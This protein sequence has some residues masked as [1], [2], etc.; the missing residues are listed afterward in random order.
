V[1]DGN[2]QQLRDPVAWR[3]LEFERWIGVEQQHPHLSPVA[4][5][6]QAGRVEEGDA[7]LERHA[8]A[9]QHQSARAV[10]NLHGETGADADPGPRREA[11]G[12]RRVEVEPRVVVMR[13]GRQRGLLVELDETKL[14]ETLA[15]WCLLSDG[16]GDGCTAALELSLLRREPRPRI[17]LR[18]R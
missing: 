10:G 3:D 18:A 11:G 4:G 1:G 7:V 6:D 14:A 16:N 2:E 8:R 5:V 13:P 9:G 17:A 12:L 15:G